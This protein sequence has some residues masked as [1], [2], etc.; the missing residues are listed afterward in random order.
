VCDR[1]RHSDARIAE[2]GSRVLGN[3]ETSPIDGREFALTDDIR[4]YTCKVK[5]KVIS[6]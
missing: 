5:V 6:L 1:A 3:F 4:Q 2:V